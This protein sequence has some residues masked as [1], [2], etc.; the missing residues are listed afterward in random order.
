MSLINPKNTN[1]Q[2]PAAV[3][4]V[5]S[6]TPGSGGS[7]PPAKPVVPPLFRPIDW[8]TLGITALLVFIGYML[9]L[10]PDLTLED[11]G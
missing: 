7:V 4:P 11:C 9:T 2:N 8:L 3:P 6:K 10:A 1:N 5:E